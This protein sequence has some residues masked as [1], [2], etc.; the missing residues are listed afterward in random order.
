M[1]TDVNGQRH[2]VA[3][4]S[5]Q[6]QHDESTDVRQVEHATELGTLTFN[7]MED[8][9]EVARYEGDDWTLDIPRE[10]EGVPVTTIANEAFRSCTYLDELA[11]PEGITTIGA[12]AFAHSGL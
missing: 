2:A 5:L 12:A 7:V 10:I 6:L 4:A 8:H 11:L 1:V 9:A 3:P